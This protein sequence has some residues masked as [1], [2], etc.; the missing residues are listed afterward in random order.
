MCNYIFV[1]LK[2]IAQYAKF[3]D[4]GDDFFND[5]SG[6]GPGGDNYNAVITRPSRLNEDD[7]PIPF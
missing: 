2:F 7:E 6:K 4:P 1:G 3:T 5:I